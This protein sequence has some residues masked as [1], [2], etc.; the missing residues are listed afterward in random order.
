M[1][2]KQNKKAK[3]SNQKNKSS[4]SYIIQRNNKETKKVFERGSR[5]CQKTEDVEDLDLVMTVAV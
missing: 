4:I 1:N 5:L 3:S 2:K